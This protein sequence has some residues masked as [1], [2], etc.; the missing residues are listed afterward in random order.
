[1]IVPAYTPVHFMPEAVGFLMRRG[2]Q[3]DD[4]L[5]E[6]L[7]RFYRGLNWYPDGAGASRTAGN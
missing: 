3:G 2:A 6:N 5:E 4:E 1:M 7:E